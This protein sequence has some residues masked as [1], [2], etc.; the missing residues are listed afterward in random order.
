MNVPVWASC[1][2][3]VVRIAPLRGLAQKYDGSPETICSHA[4]A[5]RE[6]THTSQQTDDCTRKD[7]NYLWGA[8]AAAAKSQRR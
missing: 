1:V 8:P 3:C 6:H 7:T 5:T 2:C 4:Y